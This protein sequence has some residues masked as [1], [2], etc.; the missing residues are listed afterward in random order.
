MSQRHCRK[1]KSEIHNL[2]HIGTNDALFNNHFISILFSLTDFKSSICNCMPKK[3]FSYRQVPHRICIINIYKVN[4]AHPMYFHTL[5]HLY[6]CNINHL[7]KT[8][9]IFNLFKLNKLNIL[10]KH[11]WKDSQKPGNSS[12]LWENFENKIETYS[13]WYCLIIS[14]LL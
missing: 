10:H 5:L 7:C 9:K 1:N 2:K 8:N 12:C 3:G 14:L 4:K 6:I 13:F 11:F